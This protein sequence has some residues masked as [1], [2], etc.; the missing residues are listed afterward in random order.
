MRVVYGA[1]AGGAAVWCALHLDAKR[2]A[3]TR[4]TVAAAEAST[5]TSVTPLLGAI[6]NTPLIE[7]RSLEP[8]LPEGTRV[9]GKVDLQKVAG[10]RCYTRAYV[11]GLYSR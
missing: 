3:A 4:S 1:A 10:T 5:S 7:L 8:L 9:L 2:R 11:C 6:G